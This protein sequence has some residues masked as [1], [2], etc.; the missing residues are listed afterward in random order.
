[1]LILLLI[2]VLGG[3]S[4]GG[5]E[6]IGNNTYTLS[7]VIL[8]ENDNGINYVTISY[9]GPENNGSTETESDG[10]WQIVGLKGGVTLSPSKSGYTFHPPN[11]YESEENDN[12]NF[13][14]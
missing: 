6:S 7:G 11:L 9:T 10:S 5:G 13:T 12:V 1:M 2:A 3:C 8:D 14:G 4:N